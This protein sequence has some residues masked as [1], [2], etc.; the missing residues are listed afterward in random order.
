MDKIEQYEKYHRAGEELNNKLLDAQSDEEL[1]EAAQ[2]LGM[3]VE[4]DGEEYAHHESELEI[5]A[6]A[7]FV[8]NEAGRNEKTG[9][10]RYYEAERWDS[11]VEKEILEALQETYTSLFRVESTD[12]DEGRLV[13][14]DLLEQGKS[15]LEMTDTGLSEVA[16]TGA[17]MFFR[18]V[19]VRDIRMTSGFLF[20][21]DGPPQDHLVEVYE[22]AIEKTESGD[23]PKPES[24]R[25]FYVFYRLYEKYGAPARVL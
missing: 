17:L 8:I 3:T 20:P 6:H 10:E 15:P 18:P 11:E 1:M 12:S 7:D 5:A 2:F 21:F 23:D 9:A 19:Q 4:K 22:Q 24:A 16:K 13:L 14:E 25:R